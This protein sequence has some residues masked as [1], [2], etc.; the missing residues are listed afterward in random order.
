MF[1]ERA[2]ITG[3]VRATVYG[4][5]GE[6][7]NFPI[8]PVLSRLPMF[9]QEL[10]EKLLGIPVSGRPMI[11]VNHNI[12]TDEGDAL[13]ADHMSETD[14]RTLVDNT[15]GYIEVGT[16]FTSE[17][18]TITSCVTPTGSPEVM[19]ATYPKLKGAW[20]VADDNVVQYRATFEAGDLNQTGIDEA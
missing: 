4:P 11:A 3:L 10:G 12:V 7:K 8:H 14:A 16:G 13:I 19:D 20:T 18:K 6:V 2:L 1:K 9:V 5:D 17:A 15:N